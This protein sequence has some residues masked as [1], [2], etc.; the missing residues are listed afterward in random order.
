MQNE[1]PPTRLQ[2]ARRAAKLSQTALAR[3][4]GAHPQTISTA[5]RS[6]AVSEALA[7]RL[8]PALGVKPEDLLEDR[9]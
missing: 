7:R 9:P 6:G 8:A 4:T 2:R 5:E 1:L 3:R